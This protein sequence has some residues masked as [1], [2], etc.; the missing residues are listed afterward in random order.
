MPLPTKK[1]DLEAA[2]YL[3]DNEGTC[4]GC[5]ERIEWYITPAGKK[6]PMSVV[7]VRERDSPIAPI[8][9]IQRIPHWSNCSH[10]GDFRKSKG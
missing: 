3:F 5:G 8:K 1:E 2:G 6:M 7:E 4:R 9:E 10:A